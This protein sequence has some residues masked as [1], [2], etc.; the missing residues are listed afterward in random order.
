MR[1]SFDDHM[2]PFVHKNK[3]VNPLFSEF[4]IM[5]SVSILCHSVLPLQ[6]EMLYFFFF[7]HHHILQLYGLFR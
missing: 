1:L 3:T 5:I 6:K 7:L 2:L 4:L